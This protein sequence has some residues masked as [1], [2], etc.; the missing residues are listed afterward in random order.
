MQMNNVG[1]SYQPSIPVVHWNWEFEQGRAVGS[2]HNSDVSQNSLSPIDPIQG[3]P[4]NWPNTST[5]RE[6]H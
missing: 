3:S 1:D 6:R 5:D 4:P 2:K